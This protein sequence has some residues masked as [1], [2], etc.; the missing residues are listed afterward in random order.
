[1]PIGNVR[2]SSEELG[3]SG[4]LVG[5]E[6]LQHGGHVLAEWLEYGLVDVSHALQDWVKDLLT[7]VVRVWFTTE[8]SGLF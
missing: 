1:V 2:G 7:S 6:G 4:E 5:I 3:D 8:V